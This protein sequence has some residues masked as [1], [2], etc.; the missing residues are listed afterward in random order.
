MSPFVVALVLVSTFM[1][2][3]WNLFARRQRCEAD[4]FRRMLVV[5]ALFGFVPAIWS[6]LITHSLPPRAW[7]YVAGSGFCCGMYFFFLALA[8][9][10]SDFTV[11]YPVARSIPVL[12]VAVGDL[13]RGRYV[14][15]IAWVGLLLVVGGCLL[16]PLRSITDLGAHQYLNRATLWMLL[17]AMGTV[18]YALLNKVA[19]EI[20]KQGPATAARYGY[21]FF[22]TAYGVYVTSLKVF[23]IRERGLSYP[24]WKFPILA[25]GMVFGGYW[26]V[27]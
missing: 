16:A 9:R 21:L 5:M 24:G 3:G 15:P 8:Y 27:L 14:T 25:A 1:H 13:L 10:S 6:E 17:A 23:K 18:G 7:G 4:F 20:V 22:L 12:L 11:V 19:S 2:A 26:L